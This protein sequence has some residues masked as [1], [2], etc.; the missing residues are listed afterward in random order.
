MTLLC[1]ISMIK[2]ELAGFDS[3]G[4]PSYIG[5]GCFHRR[6]TLC[7]KKYSEECEREQTMRNNNERIEENAS[8]LE[9]TCKVLA[10]CSYE[11]YTQWGKEVPTSLSPSHTHTH[12]HSF[13]HVDT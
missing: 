7:G 6:E 2:V 5:T 11:D 10:S 12:T 3:N 4:G 13:S 1:K 8:V 9:E